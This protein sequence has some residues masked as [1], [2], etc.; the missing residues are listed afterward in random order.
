MAGKGA[1]NKPV[2]RTTGRSPK[3]QPLTHP[4]GMLGG[5]AGALKPLHDMD[6][7]LARLVFEEYQLELAH[8]RELDL[9]KAQDHSRYAFRGLWFSFVFALVVI[10]AGV[11][12]A[13]A[14]AGAA[15][16]GA[17]VVPGLGFTLF[18]FLRA[19]LEYMPLKEDGDLAIFKSMTRL[20]GKQ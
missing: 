6:P 17:I 12:L 16:V 14:G 15:A 10:A 8:Q 13:A 19:R 5:L 7:D 4:Q 3:T 9:Q 20:P 18:L 2:P 11:G 1:S